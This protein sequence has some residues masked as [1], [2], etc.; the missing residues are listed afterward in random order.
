VLLARKLG[1]ALAAG[2]TV[3]IKP[4]SATPLTALALADI[5]LESGLPPGAISV[6]P[7]PGAA[8]SDALCADPRITKISF[9]GE[10]ATGAAIVRA[11]APNITRV[12]LE[13]GGKS[14]CVVFA[15][16]DLETCVEEMP[17]G[18]FDNAGQDCCARS[19]ILVQRDVHDR[20]VEAFVAR[21]GRVVVGLHDD[22][23]VEMGSLISERQRASV[24]AYVDLAR[25]E[26]AEV[27]CGGGAP[28]DPA[29][30][31]GAFMQ[32]VVL[33]GVTNSMRVAREE[34]FGPVAAVI[35]FDDEDDA[36]RIANDSDFGLSGSLWTRDLGRALRVSKALRTGILSVNSNSSAH[37][38]AVFGGFKR[39]GVGR[40]LG[41]GAF[42]HY[43]E[44]RAVHFSDR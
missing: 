8:L 12:S 4:A 30:A 42:E 15:D 39:S 11:S 32:P 35:P 43:T 28:A 27:L 38:Q 5:L 20:F 41:M 22:P 18:V 34:I 36:V 9:T 10:P 31:G 17:G 21:T 44:T 7:G 2:N 1:P 40:E 33:A 19:R 16:A 3:V 26:G 6:V 14:A 23:A 37:T 13:L 25:S 24:S 29:L